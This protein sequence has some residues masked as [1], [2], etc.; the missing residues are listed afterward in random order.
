MPAKL[1]DFASPAF[2]GQVVG[3]LLGVLGLTPDKVLD[4][5]RDEAGEPA[6]GV[7]QVAYELITAA[8]AGGL[9]KVADL[10]GCR[11]RKWR[12]PPESAQNEPLCAPSTAQVDVFRPLMPFITDGK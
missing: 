5:V 8:A 11:S 3:F 10:L 9:P 7:L 1:E 2:L 4:L 12:W 6:F